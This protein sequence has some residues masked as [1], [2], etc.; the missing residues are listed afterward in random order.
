MNTERIEELIRV[1]RDGLLK[2]TV[3]FWMRHTIDREQG[4]FLNFLDHDGAVYCTDKPVW[5][6]SRFTWL[7]ALLYDEVEKRQEWLDASAHGIDFIEKHCFDTD[8]R[9]F[10][11]VTR[12]GRPLRKRRYLFTETFGVIAFSEYARAANDEARLQKARDLYRLLLR[13]YRNPELLPPKVYPETR[14]TKGHAMPMIL[15]G[16]TQQLRKNGNDALYDEV[17]EESLREILDDFVHEDEQALFETVG[18]NGE[19]LDS[20]EGRCINPGHAMETSWFIMEEAR[21]SNRPALIPRACEILDW[22]LARGWDS[23][24]GGILYFV[25]VEGKPCVQYEHD[26]KHWWPHNEA[27]YATLLA[28]HLT[29]EK[30]YAD[31]HEKISEWTLAHFPDN[32]HGAWYKYC[33]RDGSLSSTVKGNAWAGPFHAPRMQLYCWKLLEEMRLRKEGDDHDNRRVP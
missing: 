5:V 17:I 28:Y 20:P 16:T 32:T 15:L 14:Q 12:D 18:P 13:Y 22:S 1:H 23:Q 33:H 4:G 30:R 6:L 31:W 10:Y 11:M 21:Q 9:M 19:R 2:S 3:P 7:M 24:Y 29:G 8:G 26:M 25:D 27:M